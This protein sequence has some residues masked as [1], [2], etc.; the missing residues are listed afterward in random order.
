MVKFGLL[1]PNILT[2]SKK[3]ED[4]LV[5]SLIKIVSPDEFRLD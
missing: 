2:C 5:S 3:T 1:L 4:D